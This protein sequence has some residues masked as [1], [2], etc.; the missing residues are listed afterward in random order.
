MFESL[1]K[2]SRS[3]G[4]FKGKKRLARILFSSYIRNRRDIRIQGKYCC[5]YVLPN[6]QESVAFELFL[7]GIYEIETHE[8]L[9]KV[10]PNNGV[11]FDIGANI[12]SV[13]IPLCKRRPDIKC[14]AV[15][16][17]DWVYGY[18]SKNVSLNGLDK[19]MNLLNE[20]VNETGEGEVSFYTDEKVFGKGSMSPVFS[21]EATKVKCTSF[22]KL[23]QQFSISKVDV[24]KIDIEGFEKMAFLGGAEM[25]KSADA[26]LILFEFVSWAEKHA[27]LPAG[28]AQQ[29]LMEW[30]YTLFQLNLDGSF[31]RLKEVITEG[32][33]M[34]VATKRDF[35]NIKING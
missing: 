12:G 13:A 26:P 9:M 24:I 14:V 3:T 25:L 17:S 11:Y 8:F 4:D 22:A 5:L 32:G 31:T 2:L 18:L 28:D 7:N 16:A 6:I 21:K 1:G 27:G 33:A 20:A 29:L 19:Q 23:K 35:D 30:G 10:I 34:I 15:E